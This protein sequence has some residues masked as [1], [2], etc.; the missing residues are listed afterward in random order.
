MS[1]VLC[2]EWAVQKMHMGLVFG[3]C[4]N[5]LYTFHCV[6]VNAKK[7]A[8]TRDQCNSLLNNRFCC[9]TDYYTDRVFVQSFFY[10][11]GTSTS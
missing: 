8:Q 9:S 3:T 2:Y 4:S 10:S 6:S 5:F 11:E 1:K 7:T